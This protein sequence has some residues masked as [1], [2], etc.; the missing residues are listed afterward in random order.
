MMF[1]VIIISGSP[2]GALML[3]LLSYVPPLLY[4]VIEYADVDEGDK[5]PNSNVLVGYPI[6]IDMG[7][8]T[9]YYGRGAFQVMLEQID[10]CQ[11]K[12]LDA[13]IAEASA[14]LGG[15]SALAAPRP[16]HALFPQEPYIP[17]RSSDSSATSLSAAASPLPSS[18]RSPS[19]PS[20]QMRAHP[21]RPL[22]AHSITHHQPT[23]TTTTTF[24]QPSAFEFPDS[25]EPPAQLMDTSG[26]KHLTS[27]I[28]D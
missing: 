24:G 1:H 27:S 4:K 13:F 10:A 26:D 19:A 16:S 9:I 3:K 6:V 20:A 5:V 18:T 11:F 8:K 7:Q 21:T 2:L 25:E 12:D 14:E 23:P 28:S 22:G 17:S 15:Q